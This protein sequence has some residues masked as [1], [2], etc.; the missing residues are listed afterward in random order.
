MSFPDQATTLDESMPGLHSVDSNLDAAS[1]TFESVFPEFFEHIMMPFNGPGD[2]VVRPPN[3]SNYTQDLNFGAGDIDFSFLDNPSAW[4]PM[5]FQDVQIDPPDSQPNTG[6]TPSSEAG[7]RSE[8]L[9][10]SPWSWNS[11]IPPRGV[12]A[13]S[14]HAELNVRED[15][16][17]AADQLT[18]PSAR[19]ISH[20]S[21]DQSN[22][23][24]MIRIVTQCTVQKLS[25]PSFPSLQLLEELID[26]FLLEDTYAIGSHI[27]IPTFDSK[28][29]RT[30]LLLAMVARGA[31]F[32][33][34]APIW[35]MGFVLQDVVRY[36]IA[37]EFERDN[38]TTRD[39]QAV[40]TSL[41]WVN[42]GVWSGFRRFTEIAA[43]FL[44][45]PVTMLAW[46]NAFTRSRYREIIPS[47]EDSPEVLEQK[48]R[49][50]AEQEAWKR[51]VFH[52]FLH[53]A[54]AMLVHM[55]SPLITPAQM[56][57]PIPSS[58]DLWLASN[59]LA[60]RSVFLAQ[61]TFDGGA[62]PS[63]IE[64]FS[65]PE[66]FSG[67]NHHTDKSLCRLLVAHS[68][69]HDVFEYRQQAQMLR[70]AGERRRRD[71]G[72]SHM[73][74]L[75]D[76]YDD[77]TAFLTSCEADHTT[78][79]E[80]PFV[81]EFLMMSLHVA[82]DD[83][84]LFAGREGEDEARRIFPQV[85]AWTRD[86]ES[87]KAVWH[88]GQVFNHARAFEKTRLRDFYAVAMYHATL[89]LW[90]WGMVTSGSSRQSGIATPVGSTLPQNPPPQIA[91][92]ATK[93]QAKVVLDGPESKSTKAF[94]QLGHGTP[95]LLNAVRP[96][97]EMLDARPS[98]TF[99][100]FTSLF[101]SRG[102]MTS[103]AGVLKGNF[104]H[105]KGSL[106]PLVANL[107]NLLDELGKLPS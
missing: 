52:T 28:K 78:P 77:L 29:T 88:A 19:Q 93:S 38:S 106:P 107:S 7:P 12:G 64:M 39:L 1:V 63:T 71:K 86:A 43:S 4:T 72:L 2:H 9:K 42:T 67:L 26:I 96:A 6:R 79:P 65:D 98:S 99:E 36:A 24:Q 21:L 25:M 35:K 102:V 5:P 48:W 94:V 56:Q 82:L 27:H 17:N 85:R 57:L 33:S 70:N 51:L 68:M 95:G 3:V 22:R 84:Q 8:A 10:R 58:R 32:V 45:P 97:N 100:V 53:D 69:A 80:I 37:A 92:T 83:I 91:F 75:R 15:R 50:W 61:N 54:Q 66:L 73:S 14:E 46:S 13:F 90:V 105:T 76:L 81:L 47:P 62:L 59:A 30:E 31:A 60:W 74:R 101:D 55:R 20:C 41:M 18:S 104:S 49:D 89:V 11:W 103:A 40:Q 44:Q 16:I 34:F 87:R 23:D